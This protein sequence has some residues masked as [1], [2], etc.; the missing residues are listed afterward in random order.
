MKIYKD[1]NNDKPAEG[2]L[3]F[4]SINYCINTLL[5]SFN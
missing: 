5:S 2:T 1:R 4:H 3:E